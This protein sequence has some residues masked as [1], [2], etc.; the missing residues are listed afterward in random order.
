METYKS[1]SLSEILTWDE[2]IGA[3]DID[4]SSLYDELQTSQRDRIKVKHI[5]KS[6][7]AS[8]SDLG[9]NQSVGTKINASISDLGLNQSVGGG[10]GSPLIDFSVRPLVSTSA[11]ERSD[12]N[13]VVSSVFIIIFFS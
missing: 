10:A 5:R 12:E 1:L 6:T 13:V 8:I 3:E 4:L 7:N 9:L 2:F 11:P